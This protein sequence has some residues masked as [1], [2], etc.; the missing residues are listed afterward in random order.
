LCGRETA[1][2]CGR[3]LNPRRPRK[4]LSP[5]EQ[6]TALGRKF[7]GLVEPNLGTVATERLHQMLTDLPHL[8]SVSQLVRATAPTASTLHG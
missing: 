2:S 5:D 3:R 7:D 4:P 6:A 1:T 8:D